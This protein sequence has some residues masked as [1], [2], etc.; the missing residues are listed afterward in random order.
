MENVSPATPA[1]STRQSSASAQAE[2]RIS[3]CATAGQPFPEAPAGVD[4]TVN[5]AFRKDS[6]NSRPVVLISRV[7]PPAPMIP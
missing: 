1:D 3:L 5:P 4:L 7:S 2:P 6:H